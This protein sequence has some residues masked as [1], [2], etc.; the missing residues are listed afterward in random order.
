MV[1]VDRHGGKIMA[2]G[3]RVSQSVGGRRFGSF[4]A[5][6][7]TVVAGGALYAGALFYLLHQYGHQAH[8]PRQPLGLVAMGVS[9]VG[10][11][12]LVGSLF[13]KSR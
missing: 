4:A 1:E 5:L 2:G 8:R 6:R 7:M 10:M 9:M 3:R 11:G 12:A 13:P